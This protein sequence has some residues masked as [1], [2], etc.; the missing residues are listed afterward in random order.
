MNVWIALAFGKRSK[1]RMVF[2]MELKNLKY[3]HNVK[4]LFIRSIKVVFSNE[5]SGPPYFSSKKIKISLTW[6]ALHKNW[7]FPLRISSVMWPNPQFPADLITFT[8]AKEILNGKHH[9]LCSDINSHSIR[10]DFTILPY[11]SKR[12]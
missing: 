12:N 6:Y 3:V 7:S 5:T 9:F 2:F 1:S 10:I 4:V 8:K 11:W